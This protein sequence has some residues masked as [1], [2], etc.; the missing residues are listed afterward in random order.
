MIREFFQPPRPPSL[1]DESVGSFI[2]RRVG[3]DLANNI[4][5]AVFHGIYAGDVW[6]LS[7][8]SIQPMLWFME[9]RHGSL[10]NAL[11]EIWKNKTRFVQPSDIELIAELTAKP[12][13]K[14]LRPVME[15]SSVYT[16]KRGL[17]QLADQLQAML[18]KT[19]NVH[20]KMNAL[21]SKLAHDEK[22]GGLNVSTILNT[23]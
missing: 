11:I 16:F 7:M 5:S 17:G 21:I 10:T 4:V 9:G 18:R 13:M 1:P 14:S 20:F 12:S 23:R 2:S 8:K 19:K 3:P 15:G 6:Q 22:S